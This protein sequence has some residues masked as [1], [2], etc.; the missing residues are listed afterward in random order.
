M[1]FILGAIFIL[2]VGYKITK[3]NAAKVLKDP[4]KFRQY[5]QEKNYSVQEQKDICVRFGLNYAEVS[6]SGAKKRN[7][8]PS[9]TREK[10][11]QSFDEDL[12]TAWAG[13]TR[14]IEFSYEKS[15]GKKERRQ[16][17]PNEVCFNSEGEFYIKGHCLLRNEPRTF[18]QDRITT[19]IKVGSKRYDFDDWCEEV[20]KI[21]IY[22]V[23]PNA[24]VAITG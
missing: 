6:G 3:R 10:H 4:E 15:F 7:Q 2:F 22:T 9:S 17:Q 16:V 8:T 1:E 19:K 5:V 14:T 21:D 11:F 24:A 13:D 12:I 20:I 23:C 18:K